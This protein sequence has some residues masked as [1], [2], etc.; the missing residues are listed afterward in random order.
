MYWR[1]GAVETLPDIPLVQPDFDEPLP[2]FPTNNLL[3][4][5]G[6]V[7]AAHATA[8]KTRQSVTGYVF[9]LAGGAVP[10]KSKLQ[11]TVA[12]SS[13]ESEFVAAVSGAKVVAL[14]ELN[15]QVEC[16]IYCEE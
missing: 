9:C 11:P 1:H 8:L 13:T 3:R 10:F 4:L 15:F 5:V 6:F 14:R 7:D 2:G 12:T 16:F